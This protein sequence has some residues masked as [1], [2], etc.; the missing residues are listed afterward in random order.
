MVSE[1]IIYFLVF[2]SGTASYF[3]GSRE[4]ILEKYSPSL[5]SRIIW[6][7]LAINSLIGIILSEGSRTSIFLGGIFL[8]G[9]MVIC[10]LSFYKGTKEFGWTEL[11]ALIL[12]LLSVL[13]WFLLD[14]PIINLII[15]L[16]AH[17]I[18]G[19]PTYRKVWSD[20]KSE[21]F[22]F[23]S[24]FFIASLL[25]VF[26]SDIESIKSILFPI[27][28]T[29]FDGGMALLCLRKIKSKSM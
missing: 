11:C 7:F 8:L 20:P 25:S 3:A 19:I 14:T 27:Y 1:A 15:S 26:A 22:R 21:S 6:V 23:W 13:I 5:F 29:I 17:F 16:V 24:L 28:F 9:N 10:G 2:L 18:G 12:L 4:I